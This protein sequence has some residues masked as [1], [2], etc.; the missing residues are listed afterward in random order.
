MKMLADVFK[1]SQKM[2]PKA[3]SKPV[4]KTAK[5]GKIAKIYKAKKPK[6][7]TYEG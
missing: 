5:M 3:V 7:Y 6:M 1:K 2:A 4:K